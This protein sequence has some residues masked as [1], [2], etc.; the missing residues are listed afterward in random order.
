MALSLCYVE[1]FLDYFYN[2][3]QIFFKKEQLRLKILCG[4]LEVLQWATFMSVMI[5]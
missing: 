5:I 1:L 4:V 2:R 3:K